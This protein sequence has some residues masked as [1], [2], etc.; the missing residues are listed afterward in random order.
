MKDDWKLVMSYNPK[1]IYY[2]H[3]NVKKK[4]ML[5]NLIF[6]GIVEFYYNSHYSLLQ[7][8]KIL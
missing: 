2:A 3:A 1:S 5:R 8:L 4:Y 7:D 6:I